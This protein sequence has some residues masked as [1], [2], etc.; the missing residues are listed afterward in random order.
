MKNNDW[1]SILVAW[2][3]TCCISLSGIGCLITG[4]DLSP[5][6]PV[7]LLWICLLYSGLCCLCFSNRWGTLVLTSVSVTAVL[8]WLYHG[9]LLL[10]LEKLL[11][12]ITKHYSNAYG[13]FYVRWNEISLLQQTDIDSA[14]LIFTCL[15]EVLVSWTICR[16]KWFGAG[17][18]AGLL[19][20]ILCC[21]TLD[22]PPD[23]F[24]LFSLLTALLLFLLTQR[25]RRTDVSSANRLLALLLVPLVLFSSL[26][27]RFAPSIPHEG[28]AQRFQDLLLELVDPILNPTAPSDATTDP[29][30][31]GDP[32]SIDLTEIGPSTLGNSTVMYVTSNCTD[33][34]YLRGR[35]FDYYTGTSWEITVDT[36]G[37]GGW[38][39]RNLYG[40]YTITIRTTEAAD[41]RYFPYYIQY[42]DW[43]QELQKGALINPDQ[44]R[45]YSF[46]QYPKAA[47]GTAVPALTATQKDAYLALPES[48]R[49]FAE[50]ILSDIYIPSDCTMAEQANY[51]VDYVRNSAPYDKNTNAMPAGEDFALWFLTDAESGYCTHFASA[52]VV[53]LRAAG[54]P[55]RYVTGYL[56]STVAGEACR[57]TAD[58]AHAWV[59][60]LCPEAGWTVLDPTPITVLPPQISPTSP[61]EPTAPTLTPTTAPTLTPTTPPTTPPTTQPSEPTTTP[62]QPDTTTIPTLPSTEP[63]PSS[64]GNDIG[65]GTQPINLRWMRYILWTLLIW[66]VLAGQYR[67]R[68]WLRHKRHHSGNTNRQALQRWRYARMLS[69]ISGYSAEALLPIAER[70]AF[71][72]HIITAEELAQFDLW[73]QE[74]NNALS[75]KLWLWQFFLR[76]LFA[77]A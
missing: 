49:T 73:Q 16:R 1:K 77:I 48:T 46:Q 14:L 53:L 72:Q 71:S 40:Y 25:T 55:A 38:M 41:L 69:W 39:P 70:A 76:L 20:L 74:A 44:L 33:V 57:I 58:Q 42:S 66:A 31:P 7:H 10:S 68:V 12:R 34:L 63:Q 64:G 24:F 62:T 6:D 60:F 30:S 15:L 47:Y 65:S 37:E 26:V 51:I 52:A 11:F 45:I 13:W 59:E 75:Q 4:F 54:I 22:T 43:L 18:L 17:L 5:A 61:S 32:Y 9:D 28:Y 36:Q 27:F 50:T 8:L 67:L 19:P 23:S 56:T 21:V 3:L 2:L 35:S 29:S